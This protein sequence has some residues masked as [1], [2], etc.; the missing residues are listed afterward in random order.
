MNKAVNRAAGKI[1]REFRS[2]FRWPRYIQ[3]NLWAKVQLVILTRIKSQIR[4]IPGFYRG[5]EIEVNTY[6]YV[7]LTIGTCQAFL[8]QSGATN[9]WVIDLLQGKIVDTNWLY[10]GIKRNCERGGQ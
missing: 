7:K 5:V 1:T 8:K 9:L 2:Y 10:C 6:P 3:F 4:P